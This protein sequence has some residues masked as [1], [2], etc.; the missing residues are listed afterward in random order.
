MSGQVFQMWEV[1]QDKFKRDIMHYQHI[2]MIGENRYL[3]G[4]IVIKVVRK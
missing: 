1:S 4:N 2:V 3:S